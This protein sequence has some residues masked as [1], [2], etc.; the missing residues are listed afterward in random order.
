M[1]IALEKK[2]LSSKILISKLTRGGPILGSPLFVLNAAV[3]YLLYNILFKIL[4]WYT[5]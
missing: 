1:E 3:I 4:K 5:D 2:W